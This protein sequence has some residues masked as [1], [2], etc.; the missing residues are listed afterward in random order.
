LGLLQANTAYT[1][2]VAIG[3]R[4]DFTPGT[5]GSPGIISLLNG[6]DNTGSLLTST[7]GV[8]AIANTWQ[9]YKTSFITGSSVSGDLT[10]ELSVSGAST[11]QANFDNVRLTASPTP[12]PSAYALLG[13]SLILASLVLRHKQISAR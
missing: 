2:T 13:C 5:L 9:D 8:P 1:L 7:S 10:V 6:T 12:E 11:F 4:E 3:E